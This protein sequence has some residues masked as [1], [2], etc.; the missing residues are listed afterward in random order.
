[1]ANLQ[2]PAGVAVRTALKGLLE[3]MHTHE[4]GVLADRDPEDLHKFRVALRRTRSYI[5][6]LKQTLPEDRIAEFKREFAWLGSVTGPVR[7]LDV[8]LIDLKRYRKRLDKK[9]FRS[10][11]PL[12]DLL[13]DD[14]RNAR[15]QL[16]AQLAGKRYR[17]LVSSWRVFLD[18]PVDPGVAPRAGLPIVEVAAECIRSR[19]AR[20]IRRGRKLD[21]MTETDRMHRLRIDCKKL[22]YLLEFSLGLLPNDSIEPLIATLKKL[23]NQLGEFN[24]LLVQQGAL[25]TM[26]ERLDALGQTPAETVITVDRLLKKLSSREHRVRLR[27]SGEFARFDNKDTAMRIARL[28]PRFDTEVPS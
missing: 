8:F 1:M 17:S 23:Q 9:S 4:P 10:L 20:L 3:V 7:D 22:R 6:Q 16:V 18:S 28:T 24:D 14:K 11:E 5:G 27:F 25:S 12:R 21:A 13:R 26:V 15:D 19:H 2:Q